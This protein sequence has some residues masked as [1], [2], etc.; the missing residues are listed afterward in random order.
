MNS[1]LIPGNRFTLCCCRNGYLTRFESRIHGQVLPVDMKRAAF[2]KLFRDTVVPHLKEQEL[3]VLRL[4]RDGRL[5]Q[6]RRIQANIES[7]YREFAYSKP[8]PA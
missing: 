5:D 4:K 3:L 1:Y 6:A 2:E 7:V 8:S